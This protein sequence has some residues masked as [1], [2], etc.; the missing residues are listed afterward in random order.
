MKIYYDDKDKIWKEPISEEEKNKSIYI[1]GYL[2]NILDGVKLRVS[3]N[4]DCVFLVVGEEGS[5]KSTLAFTC[6]Q[7]L[8]NMGLTIDNIA[9]GSMDAMEKLQRLPDGSTIIVDEGELLFSSRETMSKEQRQL[10]QIMKVIRQKNMIFILVSPVFFDLSKY[11]C[12]DRSKFLLRTV[13]DVQM[14]RGYWQYWGPKTKKLLYILGKKTFGSY[15]MPKPFRY[16][17]FTDYRLPFHAEYLKLKERSLKE[18]FAGKKSEEKRTSTIQIRVL[19]EK[20]ANPNVNSEEVALKHGCSST[21]VRQIWRELY[22]PM[23]N[24]ANSLGK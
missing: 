7:Y 16:G 15:T 9:E 6:G 11:I 18:A 17:R 21:Y 24:V 8:T 4:W 12:V 20:F 1:D 3:R 22:K 10:T 13:T 5:G 19:A 14:H 2:R 23:E